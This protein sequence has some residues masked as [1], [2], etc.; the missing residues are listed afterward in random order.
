MRF[1]GVMSNLD[2]EEDLAPLGMAS[3]SSLPVETGHGSDSRQ[4]VTSRQ[5]CWGSELLGRC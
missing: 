2:W 5:G 1:D 3:H 4:R